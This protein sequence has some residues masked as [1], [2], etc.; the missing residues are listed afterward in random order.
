VGRAPSVLRARAA[1]IVALLVALTAYYRLVG[2]L[3]DA[4]LWWDIA[5]L[6]LV[7]MPAVFALVW[8]VLP[9]WRARWT[10]AA[11]IGFGLLAVL[12]QHFGIHILANF[13]K[14]FAMTFLAFWFLAFFESLSWVVLV[15]AIIPLVDIYSVFKGPTK[16]IT[17]NH[18][19]TF[20][21]LSIYFPAPGELGQANLGLPDLLFFALFLAA[22]A[23]F[24][25]RPGWTW[26][27][28]VASFGLTMALAVGFS[29]DGLPALPLLSLAFLLV[30]GDLIWR[31]LRPAR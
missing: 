26:L 5:W 16:A 10:I 13:S 4:S 22:S 20:Y 2:H 17:T 6:D 31:R 3:W 1:A 11:A 21:A 29:V 15:A 18:V 9:A 30:N 8:L 23:R 27:G 7:L 24:D 19:D 14:L 12:A 28:G 25:L